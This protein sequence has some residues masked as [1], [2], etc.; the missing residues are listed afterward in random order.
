ML[1]LLIADAGEGFREALAE[2]LRG[3]YRI[4]IC[5]EGKET[6]ETILSF[7]PDLV[8]L[9][10]MLPGLD[11]VSI[12]QEAARRGLRPTV[13]AITKYANDYMVEAAGRLDV[14]Y[15]MLKP[16]DVRATAQ[17]IQDL[18]EH[19]N[20]PEV[21]H[22]DLRTTVSNTLLHL[23]ISTKLHGY[24]YLREAI[25]E[26]I[27]NP[28]QSVTKELY[29]TVGK[30]CGADKTQVERSIRSAI[31]KAWDGRDEALWRLYFMGSSA[32]EL[33]RPTNA[34]FISC[35]ADRLSMDRVI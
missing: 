16:C 17:R 11:G 4:R 34:V 15:M 5:R 6:L 27:A 2:Q 32:E 30:I 9:D 22:P 7:K 13:L 35:I 1:K 33:S 21:M 26:M 23:G 18:A 8:V 3:V 19:R 28:C 10:M 29:P 24:A 20:Q 14:G 12:L 25:L 31:G